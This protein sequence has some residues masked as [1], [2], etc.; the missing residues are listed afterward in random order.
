MTLAGLLEVAQSLWPLWLGALFIGIVL[1]AYWPGRRR[2]MQ[3]HA[4]IPFRESE[5]AP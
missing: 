4:A 5:S 1:R 2:E 3:D